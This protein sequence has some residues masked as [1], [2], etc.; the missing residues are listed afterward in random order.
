MSDT[1]DSAVLVEHTKSND[2][3][4]RAVARNAGVS[5]PPL[6][7]EDDDG[8]EIMSSATSP[9]AL[10]IV[11]IGT[12]EN[13]YAFQFHEERLNE[14][15]TRIPTDFK[16]SI[17]SVVGA[18]RTG[19][20]FLLTW[21]L[22][23]LQLH[24]ETEK[25]PA[26]WYKKVETLGNDSHHDA[27][28]WKAGSERNTTGIWMWSH[29]HL[30]PSKKMAILL[31]DTQGMFDHETTMALTASIFGFSTLLSSYQIYNV[32]KRVQ[33]DNLQQ[34]AL[35]SE[36]ARTAMDAKATESKPFQKIEFLVRDWQHFEEEDSIQDMETSMNQYLDKVMSERD[37][38]DLKD[39]R[40][41]IF[42][43]FENISCFGLCHPGF[44]VTKKKYAGETKEIEQLFLQLL[45]RYCARVFG[46]A[47]PKIIG[48]HELTAEEWSVYVKAYAE[49][50][51]SG[52]RFPTAATILEATASAN[53]TTAVQKA[54]DAYKSKMDRV[55]GPGC[56]NYVNP[57]E[58]KEEE[59]KVREGA[60]AVFNDI[61]TFGNS[62]SIVEARDSLLR[63]LASQWEVYESLNTGRNPL[64]GLEIYLLPVLVAFGSML[65]RGV[66]DWTCSPFSSVCRAGSEAL[67]HTIA[68]VAFFL[69]I[70]GFTRAQQIKDMLNRLRQAVSLLLDAPA[71]TQKTD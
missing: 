25:V 3:H 27:F 5:P 42:A 39:T 7:D 23:Y 51:T 20:S 55:A 46:N 67:S 65:L 44:A 24:D 9:Q 26:G 59:G 69:I 47:Q 60:L 18:F 62:A 14:I 58:L 34:L 16:I 68:I 6:M 2:D 57:E 30:V 56:S 1:D 28:E 48:D 53:N 38:K 64:A 11:S 8:F 10:Q 22:R 17:V 70:V 50:F 36:Y 21:F 52:A 54:L 71:K 29:P 15:V 31:V 32:D 66:M 19:K 61:A 45:D 41:Q 63:K 35:F 40:E 12:E 4:S 13:S 37:A 49:L 43:C 33:E